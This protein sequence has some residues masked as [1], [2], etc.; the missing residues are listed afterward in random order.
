MDVTVRGGQF[1]NA[2]S[3]N[4]KGEASISGEVGTQSQQAVIDGKGYNIN[5]G[6]ITLTNATE[7]ALLYIKNN[8]SDL[9]IVKEVIAVLSNSTGGSGNGTLRLYRNP[10]AGTIVTNAVNANIG[11]RNFG[12][13]LTFQ[14]L[15]YKGAQGNTITGG[16]TLITT[17][18]NSFADPIPLDAEILALPTGATLGVSWQPPTGNTSQT[19]VIL[20]IGTFLSE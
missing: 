18:R 10:T 19:A 5:T 11:N 2:Q 4:S 16:T 6:S 9:F 3:V 13:E 7:S 14:G 8:A 12:S 20:L 15:Y 17:T 1:S